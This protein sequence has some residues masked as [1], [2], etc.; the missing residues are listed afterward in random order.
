MDVLPAPIAQLVEHSTENRGVTGSSPVRCTSILTASLGRPVVSGPDRGRLQGLCQVPADWWACSSIG[1]SAGLRNRRLGVQVPPG[2]PVSGLCVL[3]STGESNG[4]LPR[5]LGVRLPQ[6]A[7]FKGR[8]QVLQS[9][10]DSFEIVFRRVF[11]TP[12]ALEAFRRTSLLGSNDPA[13]RARLNSCC[14]DIRVGHQ[15]VK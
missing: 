15:E 13:N 3:S 12:G 8:E 2:P 4:F 10:R 7:P 11:E 9:L 14:V 1:E 5:G 6:G